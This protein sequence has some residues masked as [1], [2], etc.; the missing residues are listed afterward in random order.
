M[1]ET[2]VSR[3]FPTAYTDDGREDGFALAAAE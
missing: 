1:F 3:F 2:L